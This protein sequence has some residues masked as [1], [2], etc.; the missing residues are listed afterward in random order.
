MSIDQFLDHLRF[1]K[2]YSEHTLTAYRGD[3]SDFSLFIISAYELDEEWQ[4]VSHHMIREWVVALMEQGISARSISRKISSLKS[5]YK[6]LLRQQVVD[7]NPA[8][9][10][11]APKQA[12]RVLRVA[13]EDQLE[14]LLSGEDFPP[15]FWGST[16]R[17]IFLTFY[18]TGIRLSELIGLKPADV[19]LEAGRLLV[20]GKRNKQRSIPLTPNL[21]QELSIYIERREGEGDNVETPFLFSSKSGKKLYPKLVYDT[22]NIYLR[23]VSDLQKTSPHVLRHSFATHLLNRGA[24]LN[25]IKELLGHSNLAATQ[26]YTHNSIDQLKQLYNNAHP[27]GNQKH[28]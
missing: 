1:Q 20:T 14:Q 4:E 22:I 7:H 11:V 26:V 8:S 9:Q 16:Q 19:D 6:Y 28:Q 18:H 15:D 2:R 25:S 27:R 10:V 5:F 13:S 3:L 24:D 12:R 23:K 21:Q 17:L